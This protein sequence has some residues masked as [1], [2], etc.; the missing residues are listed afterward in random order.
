MPSIYRHTCS[1]CDLK[2]AWGWG[3]SVYAVDADGE[4]QI[5]PHPCEMYQ[6]EQ[7]A[8]MPWDEALACGRV[9]Y[10]RDTLCGACLHVFGLDHDRDRLACPACGSEDVLRVVDLVGKPCPRCGAGEIVRID[11]GIIS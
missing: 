11:T 9:G 7:I 6:A 5:C 2:L 4:R 8:G 1:L 3:C 10:L